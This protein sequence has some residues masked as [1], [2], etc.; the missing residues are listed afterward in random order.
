MTITNGHQLESFQT[1]K[2]SNRGLLPSSGVNGG[3]VASH[4][5]WFEGHQQITGQFGLNWLTVF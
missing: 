1:Q 3:K 4:L 2:F 5:E